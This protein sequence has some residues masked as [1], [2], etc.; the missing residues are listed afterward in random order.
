MMFVPQ[1]LVFSRRQWLCAAGLAALL[2]AHAQPSKP[3]R[4]IVPY[5]AGGPIDATARILA[6]AVKESLGTVIIENK[7]GAGGNLG[8]DAVAKA[9]PD[10]LT[11]GIA[12][13][14][15]HAINPWL[16]AKM[17]FDAAHDFA[18]ITQWV[19]VPNVLVMNAASA[20]RLGIRRLDDLV[21]YAKAT[22]ASST[23]ALAATAA[24]GIWRVKCSNK[25][26]AFTRFTFPTTVATPRNWLCCQVKWIS[27]LT[28]SPHRRRT[29]MQASLSR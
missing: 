3:I 17:P 14:A 6:D 29:F 15:T 28:T 16:F 11:L 22:P 1:T 21:A 25:R 13:V 26:L 19:R 18:P 9:A 7:P 12:A 5:A 23:S 27:T 8:V 20:Q 4:L 2:P 10:G 24:Q